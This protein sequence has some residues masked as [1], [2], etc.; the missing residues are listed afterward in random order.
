M[1]RFNAREAALIILSRSSDWSSSSI[2]NVL[3]L[4]LNE[5][6]VEATNDELL[7]Q[8]RNFVTSIQSASF[9]FHRRQ[10]ISLIDKNVSLFLA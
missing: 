4:W 6:Y 1:Q 2:F 9:S 8:M 5:D 3:A 7:N 10:L